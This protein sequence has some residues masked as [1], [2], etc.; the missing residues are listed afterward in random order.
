[1]SSRTLRCTSGSAVAALYNIGLAAASGPGALGPCAHVTEL[2]A[3]GTRVWL[4]PS[5]AQLSVQ[6]PYLWCA[7]KVPY[8]APSLAAPVPLRC[9]ALFAADSGTTGAN[10]YR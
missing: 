2:S 1:M 7:L 8:L 10:L 4:D 3:T 5:T 6:V 9:H